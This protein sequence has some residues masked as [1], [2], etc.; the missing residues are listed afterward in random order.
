MAVK[1]QHPQASTKLNRPIHTL[2]L[3]VDASEQPRGKIT[4]WCCAA[5]KLTNLVRGGSRETGLSSSTFPGALA[6][7]I[8]ATHW[9]VIQSSSGPVDCTVN[10]Q[11]W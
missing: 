6:H 7:S 5:P 1:H 4:A 10:T 2:Q 11:H 8:W 9:H 3:P